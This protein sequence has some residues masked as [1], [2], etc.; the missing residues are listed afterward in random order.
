MR[1]LTFSLCKSSPP[2]L[3]PKL[4]MY[5][6]VCVYLYVYIY[7]YIPLE[8]GNIKWFMLILIFLQNMKKHQLVLVK[9]MLLTTDVVITWFI[10]QRYSRDGDQKWLLLLRNIY[11]TTGKH[12]LIDM[13]LIIRANL[14]IVV[15]FSCKPWGDWLYSIWIYV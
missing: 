15:I 1:I 8:W 14:K 2:T 7:T 9:K 11:S 6:Y 3:H 13:S 10:L 5:I 4:Y 12:L